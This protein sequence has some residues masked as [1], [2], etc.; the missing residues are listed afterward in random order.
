MQIQESNHRTNM[1]STPPSPTTIL[2]VSP[3]SFPMEQSKGIDLV[4]VY[5]CHSSLN[6]SQCNVLYITNC[7]NRKRQLQSPVETEKQKRWIERAIQ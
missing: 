7:R 3:E 4:E 1:T 2:H 6:S 5:S